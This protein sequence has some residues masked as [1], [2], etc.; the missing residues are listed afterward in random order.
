MSAT[1]KTVAFV[2]DTTSGM[3][4]LNKGMFIQIEVRLKRAVL[5]VPGRQHC[6]DLIEKVVFKVNFGATRSSLEF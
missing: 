4:G 6:A 2:A 5:K 1:D 3:T